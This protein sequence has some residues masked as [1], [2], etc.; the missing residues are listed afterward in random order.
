MLYG[1]HSQG[2][3]VGGL[4]AGVESEFAA[5][6]LNGTGAYIS[7]TV[8]ERTDPFDIQALIDEVFLVGRRLDVQHPLVALVQLGTDVVE[9]HAFA[10]RWRGT[11]G[12]PEG[13][14]VYVV[15]G[16]LDH[17]TFP[18]SINALTISASLAPIA[19]AG[20]DPDPFEVWDLPS[21]VTPPISGNVGALDGRPLTMVTYLDAEEGH[22][23]IQRNAE[24][25]ALAL[26]FWRDA[27]SGVPEVVTD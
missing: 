4:I 5:Y 10:P 26:R 27:L 14:H 9:P 11:E 6:V 7:V 3:L 12:H 19:P 22:F 15:N 24:A 25:R 17:T 18:R 16:L 1:G 8:I 21:E 23:T 13:S 2:S 20:W